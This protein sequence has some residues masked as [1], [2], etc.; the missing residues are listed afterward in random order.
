[1]EVPVADGI[2]GH[3]AETGTL[4][5]RIAQMAASL[6][7]EQVLERIPLMVRRLDGQIEQWSRGMQRLYS[8]SA[9]SSPRQD[10]AHLAQDGVS[11]TSR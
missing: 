4:P 5:R 3:R 11:E 10:C 7:S 2:L 6:L 1:M 9:D 8:Y